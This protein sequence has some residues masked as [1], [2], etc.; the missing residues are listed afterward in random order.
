MHDPV[1]AE[2]AKTERDALVQELTAVTGLGGR[3]RRAGSDTERMRKA[4]ANR[5]RHALRRIEQVHPELGRHLRISVRT[6]TFCRYEP[7]QD[8]RWDVHDVRARNT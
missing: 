5:I 1:R 4:V 2:R 6:G 8:T 7:A 3:P